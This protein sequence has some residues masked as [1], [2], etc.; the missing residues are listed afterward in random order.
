[1]TKNETNQQLKI[2]FEKFIQLEKKKLLASQE[3]LFTINTK[4]KVSLQ[5]FK[6]V[7]KEMMD[8]I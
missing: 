5:N 1:M 7:V 4:M 6:G 8:R 2:G 3:T